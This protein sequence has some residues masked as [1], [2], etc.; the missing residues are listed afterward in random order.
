MSLLT[1]LRSLFQRSRSDRHCSSV[2]RLDSFLS[3]FAPRRSASVSTPE[4]AMAIA[5]VY[6]CVDILSGTIASLDLQHQ[7]KDGTVFAY[8]PESPI[9]LL[10]A[11]EANDR[12]NFFT[13]L[14]NAIIRLL[15]SGNAYLLPRF[16]PKSGELES[17]LLLSEGAVAYDP[18]RNR[19][20]VSDHVFGISDDFSA[21]AIIHLKNKSLDGGYTGVSTI[22]YASL[23][24]SLSANADRQTNDGL[25]AGNQKSGFL[26][27]GNELQGIGA[28]SE[29]V[30][31]RI[32]D[33]VNR[34]IQAGQRI[35]RLSG[36][37][38]FIESSMSNSDAELL[39]VRKYSVLDVCRFFGVHPYMVFADQSTNYK[40]AENSQIN[41]L[42]QTLRPFL[43]QIEQEFSNKLLPRSRRASERIRFDLSSLFATDLRTRADYVKACVESGTMTPNEGRAFEGR[44]PIAGGDQLF[45]SC[46][47]APIDSP[48]LRGEESPKNES[49]GKSSSTEA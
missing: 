26:V 16:S 10:F 44:H 25:L 45:I 18:I 42:N 7:K 39:E 12:Q 29:D 8:Q 48:K 22:L 30:S 38:Q 6:R 33:R 32:T 20:H 43:R 24:L 5:A 14:Q 31:D 9:S 46:N 13:L 37:M 49:G 4:S 17:L 41:F 34:E 23:S 2:D 47:V 40:E 21:D 1:S 27:G 3:D 35:I 28:L 19:Y 15:L 11:G 36:S